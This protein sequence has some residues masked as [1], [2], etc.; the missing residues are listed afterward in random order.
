MNKHYTF[1]ILLLLLPLFTFSQTK[2]EQKEAFAKRD[3]YLFA[4][5]PVQ[6]DFMV[7]VP[8]TSDRDQIIVPVVIAGETYHFLWDTGATT[9]ISSQLKEK[10]GLN[11]VFNNKLS[12]ATGKVQEED[13]YNVGTLQFGGIT[14]TGVVAPAVDL[15]K[16]EKLFCIKLDGLLGTNIMRTCN[17]KI[18][19]GNKIVSFSDKKIKPQG[20]VREIKFTENFSGSPLL[21]QYVGEYNYQSLMD[22]GY[23]GGINMPDSIF[24]K[25]RIS[26]KLH[27][28]KSTGNS[29]MTIFTNTPDTEYAVVLDSLHI[30]DYFIKNQVVKITSGNI[31]LT[32]NEFF[33]NFETVIIDWDKHKIYVPDVV[34]KEVTELETFGFTPVFVDGTL[35]VNLIWDG[36]AA[37][38]QGME[39]GDVITSLNG[40]NTKNMP[41]EKWCEL[42]KDFKDEKKLQKTMDLTLLKKDGS[43]QK[44]S[45][46]EYNVFE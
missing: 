25:S 39:L 43:E 5:K 31:P 1:A 44:L 24:F 10:L 22:T 32:G 23:N 13:I 19:Y 9:I 12:D 15:S 37:Q 4:A 45:L 30:G 28:K 38:K 18:D 11:K 21:T 16:F 35:A 46:I 34:V 29:A 27:Y 26:K 33:K 6:K 3:K 17:W 40:A 7:T 8:Y 20:K 42:L 36:S 14:F 41:Q 2:Q